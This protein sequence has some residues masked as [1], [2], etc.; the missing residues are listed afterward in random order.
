GVGFGARFDPVVAKWANRVIAAG[1]TFEADSV[2]IALALHGNLQNKSFYTKII[3]LMPFLG[4]NLAAARVPLIDRLNVG[5]ATNV[6][7]SDGDFSQSSGLTSNGA[8]ERLDTR[9]V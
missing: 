9:I 1:G 5:I 4:G 2:N 6:N 3:Y 8:N 7:F